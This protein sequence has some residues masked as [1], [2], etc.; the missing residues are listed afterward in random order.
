MGDV[1]ARLELLDH[2]VGI[3][4]DDRSGVPGASIRFSAR[5]HLGADAAELE[6]LGFELGTEG[7]ALH[8]RD[9][10]ITRGEEPPRI[11]RR[12]QVRAALGAQVD[13]GAHGRAE[14]GDP[15]SLTLRD[16]S[17]CRG[18]RVQHGEARA[19]L[20]D[21]ELASRLFAPRGRDVGAEHRALVHAVVP[22]G[23]K[24]HRRGALV[25]RFGA[26]NARL[27]RFLAVEVLEHE[28]RRP[29]DSGQR[30]SRRNAV[31]ARVSRGV[32]REVV[33]NLHSVLRRELADR[34]LTIGIA[35]SHDRL[36]GRCGDGFGLLRRANGIAQGGRPRVRDKLVVADVLDRERPSIC[37]GGDPDEGTEISAIRSRHVDRRRS[38]ESRQG[39]RFLRTASELGDL[40][41]ESGIGGDAFR[42]RAAIRAMEYAAL[43]RGRRIETGDALL[44]LALAFEREVHHVVGD[45]FGVASGLK[46]EVLVVLQGAE[47]RTVVGRMPIG[48]EREPELCGEEQARHLRP[49]LF[50]RVIRGA[51]APCEV[52]VQ[53]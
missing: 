42:H 35:D 6:D 13:L 9:E 22:R 26:R 37:G 27:L 16:R 31:Q 25:P 15:N 49:E 29:R 10:R 39:S 32:A 28:E 18:V 3:H 45:L 20:L 14:I 46:E 11:P 44:G 4:G 50:L 40:S 33:R 19:D 1:A 12:L 48:I 5:V 36:L 30:V 51:E 43:R 34:R 38:R 24:R 17:E 7:D 8:R 41:F 52:T 47:P 23:P 2:G 21:V 53:A